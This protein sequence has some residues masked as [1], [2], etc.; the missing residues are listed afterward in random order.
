MGHDRHAPAKSTTSHKVAWLTQTLEGFDNQWLSAGL[1]A[2]M[3]WNYN[4]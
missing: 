1:G 2:L 4:A 3:Q